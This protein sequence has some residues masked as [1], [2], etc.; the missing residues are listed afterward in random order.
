MLL[1]LNILKNC[2]DQS[3]NVVS[4]SKN[5]KYIFNL[6]LNINKKMHKIYPKIIPKHLAQIGNWYPLKKKLLSGN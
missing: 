6:Q 5:N 2:K 1:E 4:I 3:I